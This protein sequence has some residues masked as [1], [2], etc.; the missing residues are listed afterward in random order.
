MDLFNA[1][2]IVTIGNGKMTYLWESN[3]IQ[4][5]APSTI[6]PNLYKKA[7]RKNIT[8]SK[9]L[10]NNYW[11]Q[12]CAPFTWEEEV[13]EFVSLWHSISSTQGLIDFEDTISWRWKTDEEYSSSS[14][15]K[16]HVTTNFCKIKI[17][18]IWKAKNRTKMTFLCLDIV[19]QQHFNYMQSTKTGM[20]LQSKLFSL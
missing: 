7:R 13:R 20:A 18:P 14:A 2:I 4:G 11:I 10:R 17:N 1:S 5:Q 16:I 3:W 8:V 12:L 19:A 6:A 9:A 15:Y